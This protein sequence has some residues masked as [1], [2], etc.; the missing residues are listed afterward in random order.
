VSELD[1]LNLCHQQT[2]VAP[3]DFEDTVFAALTRRDI[4]L[5]CFSTLLVT[6]ATSCLDEECADLLERLAELVE[7]Q[8]DAWRAPP[9]T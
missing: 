7:I 3:H 5:L 2:H 6:F 8:K 9:E 1:L 4:W